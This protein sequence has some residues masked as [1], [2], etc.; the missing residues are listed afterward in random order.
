MPH[1]YNDRAGLAAQ[2]ISK[3][4]IPE[5]HLMLVDDLTPGATNNPIWCTYGPAPYAGYVIGQDGVIVASEIWAADIDFP[6]VIDAH[7]A[8]R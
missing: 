1:T 3:F 5:N 7:L 8:T 4:D 6:K 2:T